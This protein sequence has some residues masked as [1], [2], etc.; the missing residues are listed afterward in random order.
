MSEPFKIAVFYTPESNLAERLRWMR[1]RF[2]EAHITLLAPAWREPQRAAD[3]QLD[4]IVAVPH[5]YYASRHPL[6]MYRMARIVRQHQP[7]FFVVMVPGIRPRMIAGMSGVERCECWFWDG[8]I[9]RLPSF[10]TRAVWVFVSR[11]IRGRLRY[12]LWRLLIRV[13]RVPVRDED[14]QLTQRVPDQPQLL[15]K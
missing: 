5:V 1:R 13:W 6:R 3:S 4:E 10:V 12:P 14:D 7:D 11:I 2:P 9:I 15:V 8:R